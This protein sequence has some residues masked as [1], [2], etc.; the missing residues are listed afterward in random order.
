MEEQS[1]KR[2][3]VDCICELCKKILYLTSVFVNE[4]LNFHLDNITC[5]KQIQ[6]LHKHLQV[7]QTL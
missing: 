1:A 5:S 4:E 6:P 3:F 2:I 7:L